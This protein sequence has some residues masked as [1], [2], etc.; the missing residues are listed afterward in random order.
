[1]TAPPRH[2]AAELSRWLF[3]ASLIP[4]IGLSVATWI[5]P[6]TVGR[7]LEGQL[8]GPAVG[9]SGL[10]MHILSVYAAVT[11]AA[12]GAVHGVLAQLRLRPTR[13]LLWSVMPAA[14]A[15]WVVSFIDLPGAFGWLAAGFAVSWWVDR[16]TLA[17]DPRLAPRWLA[18]RSGFAIVAVLC[19]GVAALAP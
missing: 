19:L 14:W 17:R 7:A 1:M 3:G 18:R 13:A 10:V 5:D 11:L 12:S 9:V 6:E 2:G 8:F 4:L 15:W 16:L